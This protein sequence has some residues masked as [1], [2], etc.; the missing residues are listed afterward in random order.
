VRIIV[1]K[2]RW[3]KWKIALCAIMLAFGLFI[4]VVSLISFPFQTS[5]YKTLNGTYLSY[6][7]EHGHRSV[8][9]YITVETSE[10][11]Q[12]EHIIHSIAFPS[13]EKFV[14]VNVVSV[15]DEIE[16]TL[17]GQNIVAIKANGRSYL[18]L[19]DALK[20]IRDNSVLG[21]IFGTV[22]ILISLFAVSTQITVKRRR[23]RRRRK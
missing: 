15:G 20:E 17:D 7:E 21:Y 10:A 18:A 9:A 11:E 2:D 5:K 4:I 22:W 1:N 3:T 19:E 13:F 6:R 23:R 16:L 14:F 8:S 12:E